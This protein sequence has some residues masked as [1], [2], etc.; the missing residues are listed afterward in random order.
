MSEKPDIEEAY[1]TKSREETLA[2]F[3][4][5]RERRWLGGYVPVEE[6]WSE[7]D[8]EAEGLG[9]QVW[10]YITHRVRPEHPELIKIANASPTE[11]FHRLEVRYAPIERAPKS[12]GGLVDVIVT[13]NGRCPTC[14]LP[15]MQMPRPPYERYCDRCKGEFPE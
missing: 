6:R 1:E 12:R 14:D 2:A 5:D 11:R 8:R 15:T 9:P 13:N 3:E 10:R 4:A 7:P